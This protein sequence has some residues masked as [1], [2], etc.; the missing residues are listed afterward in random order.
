[1]NCIN[2]NGS[3]TL[4]GLS[5]EDLELLQEGLHRLFNES[6]KDE[7]REFRSQVLRIDRAIDPELEKHIRSLNQ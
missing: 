5:I 4:S 7:H 2:D 6:Q 3:F 1:M